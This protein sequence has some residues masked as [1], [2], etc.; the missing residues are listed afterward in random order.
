MPPETPSG[1]FYEFN[2]RSSLVIPSKISPGIFYEFLE[3]FSNSVIIQD[4]FPRTIQYLSS[5]EF[6]SMDHSQIPLW[7]S[8]GV[9]LRTRNSFISSSGIP[10][11]ISWRILAGIPSGVALGIL[12]GIP[13]RVP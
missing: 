2:A 8:A 12:R 10:T 9:P 11:E 6:S 13:T 5:P 4:Y 3:I 1:E 7:I